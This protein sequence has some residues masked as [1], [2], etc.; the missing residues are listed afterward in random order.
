MN[1]IKLNRMLFLWAPVFLLAACGNEENPLLVEELVFEEPSSPAGPDTDPTVY[2]LTGVEKEIFLLDQFEDNGRG[3]AT[4]NTGDYSMSVNG[5]LY[6]IVNKTA[7][8]Q[9]NTSQDIAI[10][11]SRNFDLTAELKI[12]RTTAPEK[13]CGLL[14]GAPASDREYLNLL[15]SGHGNFAVS[16]TV[17]GQRE[18]LKDWSDTPALNDPY[19]WATLTIRKYE[20][21]FYY[22]INYEYTGFT[23]P[24]L[25]SLDARIGF[26]LGGTAMM[27]VE[28]VILIYLD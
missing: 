19:D 15:I 5:G 4:G 17:S 1:V 27:E 12:S 10:D 21:L 23:S 24:A 13:S 8:K 20:D 3:W 16:R 11:V 28:Y 14:L 9:W 2:Y 6:T 25:P 18:I 22:F 26:S 7:D